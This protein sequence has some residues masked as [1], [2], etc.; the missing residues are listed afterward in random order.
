METDILIITALA[1]EFNAVARLLSDTESVRHATGAIY[2]R[3]TF[4]AG[5][6]NFSVAVVEAGAGNVNAAQETERALT[7]FQ[8]GYIF[9]V[10]V[11]GGLKDV[12]IGDVVISSEVIHYEGG[13]AGNVYKPRLS[14]Y[15]ANYELTALAKS[16]AREASWQHRIDDGLGTFKA[17]VK[18]IAAGEKVVASERSATYE[19]IN[20][21]VSQALAVEMEGFGFLAPIHAHHKKGIVIRGISDLLENKAAADAGGSQPL[22]ARNAAAFLAEMLVELAKTLPESN[23]GNGPAVDRPAVSTVAAA[24]AATHLL[25]NAEWRHQVAKV[26]GGLY[27]AGPTESGGAWK[28]AGGKVGFLS[29][30][31]SIESQWFAALERL[32]QGG[33]GDITIDSLLKTVQEDFSTNL[34]VQQFCQDI[35]LF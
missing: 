16:I 8:S 31:S 20:Q 34:K 19:L 13:K 4:A 17:E 10:G 33:A 23:H 29:N 3:G 27:E 12:A 21:S 25:D 6:R 7:F 30:N 26:L 22:A 28:R 1:L 5:T 35:S 24:S 9:F 14:T 32:A 18:P 2:K 11:A 15:P